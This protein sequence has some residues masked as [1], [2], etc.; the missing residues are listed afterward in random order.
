MSL[1]Y[2]SATAPPNSDQTCKLATEPLDARALHVFEPHLPSQQYI[3][4]IG[5]ETF[6]ESIDLLIMPALP[7]ANNTM[8]CN[9]VLNS[10]VR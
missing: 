6:L 3:Y 1:N 9:A 4:Q 10:L 2:M 5:N 7:D 8:I